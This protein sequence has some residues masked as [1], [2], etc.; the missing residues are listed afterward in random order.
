MDTASV[1]C[2]WPL[3]GPQCSA[4]LTLLG[5]DRGVLMLPVAQPGLTPSRHC[6]PALTLLASFSLLLMVWILPLG[7][8][9]YEAPGLT[10]ALTH[11]AM[12]SK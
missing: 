4:L 5:P 10:C 12:P 3:R 8:E 1:G 2:L 11:R 6:R 7:C 9:R